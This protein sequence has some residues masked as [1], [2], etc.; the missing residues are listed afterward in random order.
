M[1]FVACSHLLA[2]VRGDA[3]AFME[4]EFGI[5]TVNTGEKV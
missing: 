2:C 1:T 5:T 4:S 3:I